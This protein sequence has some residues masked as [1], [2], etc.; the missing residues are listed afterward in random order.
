M[1][2]AGVL[3]HLVR[4]NGQRQMQEYA[5]ACIALRNSR[6]DGVHII[7]NTGREAP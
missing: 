4:D 3:R 5:E 6:P 2:L 1:V 7:M